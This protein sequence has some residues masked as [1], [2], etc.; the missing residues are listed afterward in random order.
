MLRALLVSSDGRLR[1]GWAICVF[2]ITALAVGGPLVLLIQLAGFVPERWAV[3][4]PRFGAQSGAF[5]LAVL[6]ATAAGC[7]AVRQPFVSAGLGGPRPLKRLL[8]GAGIGA[9]LVGL[10]SAVPAL[11][12][13]GEFELSVA[14]P[15]VLLKSALSQLAALGPSSIA[16]EI[17]LRGFVLQQLVR[18]TNRPIAVGATSALFGLGHLDNPSAG[19]LALANITLV[20]VWLAAL[21]LRSGSLWLAIGAHASWN[22]FEGFV[23]GQPVSGLAPGPSLFLHRAL[24]DGAWTGGS[25]GPEA[26]GPAC[27]LL[28]AAIALSLVLPW[29]RRGPDAARG[30][31]GREDPGEAG[32]QEQPRGGE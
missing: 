19:W 17:A 15:P 5:L 29:P 13:R 22:W 11:V 10:A 3:D 27:A 18:G 30:G 4:E 24:D 28:L 9:G 14:P 6:A 8:A 31:G 32:P 21:T 7:L 1:S 26:G 12:G 23:F 25:F 16:E 2:A 20:G